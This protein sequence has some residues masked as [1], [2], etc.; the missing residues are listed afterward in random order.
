MLVLGLVLIL[1]AAAVM[2]LVI[3]A[4]ANDPATLTLGNVRW[5]TSAVALFLAGVLAMLV[6]IV[7]L[8]L[9]RSGMRRARQRR[10]DAK[11]LGE[12]S[13]KLEQREAQTPQEAEQPRPDGP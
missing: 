8:D 2:I 3:A 4:G 9:L 11:K 12:L 6:L 10:R 5:D 13:A 1:L 7:G